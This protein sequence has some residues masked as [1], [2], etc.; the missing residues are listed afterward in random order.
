MVGSAKEDTEMK[1]TSWAVAAIAALAITVPAAGATL[2]YTATLSGA[3]ESPPTASPG[4]GFATITLDTTA[5]TMRVEANF[6]GL[7][8][9]TTAAHIHCCTTVANTGNAGVATATP[10]FTGFPSGVTSGTYDHTFDM[11]DPAS[12]N[13]AFVTAQGN[14]GNALT[15]LESGLNSG[16]AYFN[17]HTSSFGGGEIRGF[18]APVPLPA[19]AWLLLSGLGAIGTL[20]RRRRQIA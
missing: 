7:L 16:T 11:T 5:V 17:I 8:G 4:T 13:P 1:T 10:T 14:V 2:V 19:A 15:A 3:A 12:F 20:A 9:T 18:L 6:S